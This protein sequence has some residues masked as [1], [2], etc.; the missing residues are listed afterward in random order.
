[1][2]RRGKEDEDKV[3]GR[4]VEGKGQEVE[5]RDEEEEEVEEAEEEK[6][7]EGVRKKIIIG[8]KKINQVDSTGEKV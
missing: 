7:K 6:S 4:A 2:R 5:E 3:A 1:M 8:H